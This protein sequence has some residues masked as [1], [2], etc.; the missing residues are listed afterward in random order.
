MNYRTE[1]KS[2]AFRPE[3]NQKYTTDPLKEIE[4]ISLEF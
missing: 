3:G 4:T 1:G 2:T